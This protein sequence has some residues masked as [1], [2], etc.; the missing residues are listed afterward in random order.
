MNTPRQTP[1]TPGDLRSAIIQERRERNERRRMTLRTFMQGGLT[2]RRRGGRRIGEHE[3]L[4][5]WHEP[6]LLFLAV[7][8]VLL[9]V[10]D[11]FL[12]V[13]LITVG[14]HEANPFLAYIL[15]DFPQLFAVV[16]MSLTG[17]GVVVLVAM[18]RAKVFRLIR[19]ST[20]MHWFLI[21]YAALIAYEWWL[22]RSIL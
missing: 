9:N 19:V 5:D 6:H 7:T 21:G 18:A 3:V 20:L 2:P 12:T 1:L 11:A 4:V 17:V 22:L 15:N 8:I 10:A 13:T 16:K 14:A